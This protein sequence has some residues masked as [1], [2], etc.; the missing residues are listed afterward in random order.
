MA[1]RQTEGDRRPPSLVPIKVLIL[2]TFAVSFGTVIPLTY[3]ARCQ[4][5]T[6]IQRDLQR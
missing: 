4:Y 2:Y 6:R 3:G 1:D 5:L